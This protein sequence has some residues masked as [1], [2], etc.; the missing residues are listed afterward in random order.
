MFLK[1]PVMLLLILERAFF[2]WLSSIFIC[3]RDMSVLCIVKE[4]LSDEFMDVLNEAL[5]V[6]L[7]FVA[8]PNPEVPL[9]VALRSKGRSSFLWNFVVVLERKESSLGVLV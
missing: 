1:M 4:V 9:T 2:L 8:N 7:R 3:P 6:Y 5:W